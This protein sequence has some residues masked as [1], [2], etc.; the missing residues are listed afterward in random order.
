M[1]VASLHSHPSAGAG[2]AG[3]TLGH[4]TVQESSLLANALVYFVSGGTICRRR[5]DV[6]S[7]I[8]LGPWVSGRRQLR[9]PWRVLSPWQEEALR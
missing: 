6:L 7:R 2:R 5:Y 1:A 9:L 3:A 8:L 4:V